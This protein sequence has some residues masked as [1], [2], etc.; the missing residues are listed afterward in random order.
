MNCNKVLLLLVGQK[1]GFGQLVSDSSCGHPD[2]S[3]DWRGRES[4]RRREMG[5][6]EEVKIFNK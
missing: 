2:F 3:L 1:E 5:G 4:G 6:L